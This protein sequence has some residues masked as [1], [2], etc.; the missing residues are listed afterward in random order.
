LIW[1]LPNQP[2]RTCKTSTTTNSNSKHNNT[3]IRHTQHQH[4]L[5]PPPPT[6]AQFLQVRLFQR[7]Q[8]E[9]PVPTPIAQ[10][11]CQ[12][13]HRRMRRQLHRLRWVQIPSKLRRRQENGLKLPVMKLESGGGIGRST[14]PLEGP[15]GVFWVT[16]RSA[17]PSGRA[18]WA[19]S[20]WPHTTSLGRRHVT[21]FSPFLRV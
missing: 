15:V 19:K 16:T 8:P 6:T 1:L 20:N 17:K 2:I 9:A 21:H 10:G 14:A 11:L 13:H 7:R 4:R 12:C 18:V 5:Q 3:T